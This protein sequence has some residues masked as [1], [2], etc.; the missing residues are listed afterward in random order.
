MAQL[1]RARAN[2]LVARASKQVA[3][4]HRI[5]VPPSSSAVTALPMKGSRV[6]RVYPTG[7]GVEREMEINEMRLLQLEQMRVE[8]EEA[9]ERLEE[10]LDTARRELRVINA[11][12]TDMGAPAP[13]L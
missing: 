7:I 11:L 1:L 8:V 13:F 12:L 6:R 9:V 3:R 10:Q 5:T 4:M 2:R